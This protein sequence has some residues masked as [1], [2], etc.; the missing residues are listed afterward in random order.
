MAFR[1]DA[2]RM[3][4][5]SRL[6]PALSLTVFGVNDFRALRSIVNLIPAWLHSL[7]PHC[8]SAWTSAR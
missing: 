5:V 2:N 3:V 7:P 1:R 4:S 6:L 8:A